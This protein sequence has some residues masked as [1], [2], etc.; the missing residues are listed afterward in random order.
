[1]GQQQVRGSNTPIPS[2]DDVQYEFAE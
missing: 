1:M 2:R